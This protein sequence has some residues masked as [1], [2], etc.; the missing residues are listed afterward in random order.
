MGTSTIKEKEKEK[1]KVRNLPLMVHFEK[2]L[3]KSITKLVA[4]LAEFNKTDETLKTWKEF[5]VIPLEKAVIVHVKKHQLQITPFHYSLQI[6]FT[7][8]V[9]G[10]EEIYSSALQRFV[11]GKD[12]KMQVYKYL[13]DIKDVESILKNIERELEENY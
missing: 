8:T 4:V 1:T 3:P 2:E 5:H 11:I 13:A 6:H 9:D 10:N 12:V 7:T